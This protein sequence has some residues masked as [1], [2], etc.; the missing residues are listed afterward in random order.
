[1]AAASAHSDQELDPEAPDQD[2][3][4][5]GHTVRQCRAT[6]QAAPCHQSASGGLHVTDALH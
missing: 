4:E 5:L 6:F 3:H 2:S 1:M